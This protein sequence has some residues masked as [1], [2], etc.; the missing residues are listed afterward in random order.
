M[1]FLVRVGG[2]GQGAVGRRGRVVV[3]GRG[4]RG[5]GVGVGAGICLKLEPEPKISKMSGSG[6]P[7]KKYDVS[8]PK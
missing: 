3:G 2:R 8:R 4:R 1:I 5:V 7:A 6:N